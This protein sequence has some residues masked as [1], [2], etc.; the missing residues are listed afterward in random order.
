MPWKQQKCTIQGVYTPKFSASGGYLKQ[1]SS[2]FIPN[3]LCGACTSRFYLPVQFAISVIPREI[4]PCFASFSGPKDRFFYS[5]N[6]RAFS[7]PAAGAAEILGYL[8][9]LDKF[10][11]CFTIFGSKVGK[12]KDSIVLRNTAKS[13]PAAGAGKFWDIMLIQGDPSMEGG[14]GVSAR[15]LSPLLAGSRV[16]MSPRTYG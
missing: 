3:K 5:I 13:L 8:V 6:Q 16:L 11:L 10:T 9:I 1:D 12:F 4:P 7:W 2:V 14:W 15:S